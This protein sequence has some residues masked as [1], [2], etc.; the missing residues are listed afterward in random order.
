MGRHMIWGISGQD[1]GLMERNKVCLF[2]MRI[3]GVSG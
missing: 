3:G 1:K 2:Y